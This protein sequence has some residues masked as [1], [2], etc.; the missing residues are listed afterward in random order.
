[1]SDFAPGPK[2]NTAFIVKNISSS[3][4]TIKIFGNK[5]AWN[6]EFDLLGIPGVAEEDIRAS[7]LKGDLLRRLSNQTIEIV[8]SDINLLQFNEEQREFLESNGITVGNGELLDLMTEMSDIQSHAQ[9]PVQ[10]VAEL[11][12]VD[13]SDLLDGTE[14]YVK[15]LKDW[16]VL[17]KS[18]TLTTEGLNIE[19]ALGGGQWIRKLKPS[20][21]WAR[22]SNFY[23]DP[24]NGDDENTGLTAQLALATVAEFKR[25]VLSRVHETN[26]AR[27]EITCHV[28]NDVDEDIAIE[29]NWT[30]S[31][32]ISQLVTFDGYLGAVTAATGTISAVTAANPATNQEY[33]ITAPLTWSSYIGKICVIASGP[34]MGTRFIVLKDLGS[35]Q[36]QISMPGTEFDFASS[37]VQVGD[38]FQILE[39]PQFGNV[40]TVSGTGGIVLKFLQLGRDSGTDFNVNNNYL[41]TDACSCDDIY[42]D[43]GSYCN[44]LNS[45]V[46]NHVHLLNH[47]HLNFFNSACLSTTIVN[48]AGIVSFSNF[49]AFGQISSGTPT[50]YFEVGDADYG[51]WLACFDGTTAITIGNGYTMFC[52]AGSR[53]WGKNFTGTRIVI[54]PGGGLFYRSGLAPSIAGTGAEISVGGVGGPTTY[55]QLPAMNINNGAKAVEAE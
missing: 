13:S 39:L 21:F 10:N 55:S 43:Y 2:Q 14:I 25:R 40:L 27:Y 5:I 30:T 45:I 49:T 54:K 6:H 24:L 19:N 35:N 36:V 41:V 4:R 42:L 33:T 37:S 34:R 44:M 20:Q 47:S 23:L 28:L 38:S 18:S 50:G 17:D 7:L 46:L 51:G 9:P 32:A 48:D 3:R 8:Q 15:T 26:S 29:C 31:F 52:E 1:M 16:F 22:Q 53:I 12:T 11:L